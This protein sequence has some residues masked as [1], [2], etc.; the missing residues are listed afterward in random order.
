MMLVPSV[1]IE[2]PPA[3]EEG[4]SLAVW[5]EYHQAMLSYIDWQEEVEQWRGHVEH[6]LEQVEEVTRLVPEILE[7]LGP[8]TLTPEHQS[9]VKNA[10][11]H[12][13][14]LTGAHFQTIYADLNESFHVAKYDQIPESR[15]LDVSVWLKTRIDAADKRR[16]H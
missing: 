7:R 16:K 8:Q 10:V 6:R 15:W 12:L 1:P 13:S 4:A 2:R 3:P 5:R 14:E 9:T 11:R